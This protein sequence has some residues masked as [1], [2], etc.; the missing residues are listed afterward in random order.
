MMKSVVWIEKSS[1]PHFLTG[2]KTIFV[3]IVSTASYFIPPS[4]ASPTEMWNIPELFNHSDFHFI[5]THQTGIQKSFLISSLYTD[6]MLQ[7]SHT[8]RIVSSITYKALHIGPLPQILTV[9][10][11]FAVPKFVPLSRPVTLF[12]NLNLQKMAKGHTMS[13]TVLNILLHQL[14]P[15]YIFAHV[16]NLQDPAHHKRYHE[17]GGTSLL[18]F[19]NENEPQSIYVPCIPCQVDAPPKKIPLSTATSLSIWHANNKNMQNNIVEHNSLGDFK[20]RGIIQ[21]C[22]SVLLPTKGG[23]LSCILQTL[24]I[25]HNFT[26]INEDLSHLLKGLTR[27]RVILTF[28]PNM[29]LTS[30]IY[31]LAKFRSEIYDVAM[32]PYKFAVFTTLPSPMTNYAA[33]VSP[34]DEIT[35]FLI[36][37]SS[38]AVTVPIYLQRVNLRPFFRDLFKVGALLL[39]QV[40]GNFS[41]KMFPLMTTWFFACYILMS[42]LYGGEIFSYL[43]V[44]QLPTL[45]T[46]LA[47]L[48][49]SGMSILTSSSYSTLTKNKRS[50]RVQRSILKSSLI[51]GMMLNLRKNSKLAVLIAKINGT[52]SYTKLGSSSRKLLTGRDPLNSGGRGVNQTFAVIDTPGWLSMITD[53]VEM[54]GQLFVPKRTHDTPFTLMEVNEVRKNVFSGYLKVGM[55]QLVGSGIF[56]KWKKSEQFKASLLAAGLIGKSMRV[57]VF[58]QTLAGRGKFASTFNEAKPIEIDVLIAVFMVC[59][60]LWVCAG[61]LWIFEIGWGNVMRVLE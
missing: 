4:T 38:I 36:L 8:P 47:D 52:L 50:T 39:N 10:D 24:G 49:E 59:L 32:A 33:F 41:I 27:K 46:N 43:T 35:W 57:K 34:I 18:F 22:H 54:K 40:E 30:E 42:N 48:A 5:T 2:T 6:I 14:N 3:L 58:A 1:Q 44:T 9:T 23:I 31:H 17:A 19:W 13:D 45:P 55:R 12:V 11:L 56:T 15:A 21:S 61:V 25:K 51:P 29:L 20:N 26:G 53:A 7:N 37:L 16:S 28:A 60:S